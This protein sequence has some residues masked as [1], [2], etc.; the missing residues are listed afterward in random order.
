MCAA[1]RATLKFGKL[2][3]LTF[4]WGEIHLISRIESWNLHEQIWWKF[5]RFTK[6]TAT[7]LVASDI[8]DLQISG[9]ITRQTTKGMLLVRNH[10][11]VID[12]M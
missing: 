3:F 12:R 7:L 8:G 4:F 2:E 6:S 9:E 1:F 10:W 5:P 11:K